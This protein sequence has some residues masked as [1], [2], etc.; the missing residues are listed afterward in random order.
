MR[1]HPLG[2][3]MPYLPGGNRWSRALQASLENEHQLQTDAFF[4]HGLS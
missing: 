4:A 1:N 2:E 3:A